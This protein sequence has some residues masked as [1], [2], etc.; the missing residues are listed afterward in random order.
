MYCSG[1][2]AEVSGILTLCPS[3]ATPPVKSSSEQLSREECGQQNDFPSFMLGPKPKGR[4]SVKK[5]IDVMSCCP[6]AT[7]KQGKQ[8]N[9]FSAFAPSS[10]MHHDCR[11]GGRKK[12]KAEPAGLFE[13]E[14]SA[15]L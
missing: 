4:G 7:L 11:H 10:R 3:P 2:W 5:T 9:L 1:L 13:E 12:L 15:G 14:E 6:Q 8:K